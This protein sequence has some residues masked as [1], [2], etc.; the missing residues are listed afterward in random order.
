MNIFASEQVPGLSRTKII[1]STFKVLEILQKNSSTFQEDGNPG[2]THAKL[3][4]PIKTAHLKVHST[5]TQP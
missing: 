4:P 1:S 5:Q 3:K 2:K